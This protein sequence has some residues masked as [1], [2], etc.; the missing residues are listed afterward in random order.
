MDSEEIHLL[1]LCD[2]LRASS[3]LFSEAPQVEAIA[4]RY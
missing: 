2:F 4:K 1:S 3:R